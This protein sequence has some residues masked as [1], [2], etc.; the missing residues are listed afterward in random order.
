M[1][2]VHVLHK[3]SGMQMRSLAVSVGWSNLVWKAYINI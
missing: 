3:G 1:F 2:A